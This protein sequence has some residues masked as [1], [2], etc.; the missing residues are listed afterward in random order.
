MH[1]AM[2]L[3]I[4][5]IVFLLGLLIEVVY[6]VAAPLS[7]QYLVD[8][9]FLEKNAKVFVVILYCYSLVSCVPSSN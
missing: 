1:H 4:L 6:A 2:R 5:G 8:D 7:L 3:K 9:A